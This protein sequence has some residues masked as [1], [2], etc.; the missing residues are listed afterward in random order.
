MDALQLNRGINHECVGVIDTD[1]GRGDDNGDDEK[2]ER[3]K[4]DEQQK[5]LNIP[6]QSQKNNQR[7]EA[8]KL[9]LH[10]VDLVHVFWLRSCLTTAIPQVVERDSATSSTTTEHDPGTV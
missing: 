2:E 4:K 9:T 8:R 7:D 5:L 10:F 3:Q 6:M 1:D